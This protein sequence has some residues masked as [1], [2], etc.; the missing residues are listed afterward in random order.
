MKIH[1]KKFVLVL[2]FFT[3]M[4]KEEGACMEDPIS[5]SRARGHSLDSTH[6]EGKK[7]VKKRLFE[8]SKEGRKKTL[9]HAR[10]ERGDLEPLHLRLSGPSQ[11]QEFVSRSAG[12]FFLKK[13]FLT[14]EKVDTEGLEKVLSYF[15]LN[16]IVSFGTF[17]ICDPDEDGLDE[18]PA[19]IDERGAFL[20]ASFLREMSSSLTSFT[21]KDHPIGYKGLAA[22]LEALALKSALENLEITY[23][24]G[25]EILE[26]DEEYR[27]IE[28]SIEELLEGCR[29]LKTIGFRNTLALLNIDKLVANFAVLPLLQRLD[30]SDNYLTK[31]VAGIFLEAFK[32]KVGFTLDL[33]DNYIGQDNAEDLRQRYAPFLNVNLE[34]QA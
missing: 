26:E 23:V 32:G 33:S 29:N 11:I 24:C 19:Y 18:N 17:N 20:L 27:G 5:P 14:L 13:V 16:K 7:V 4:G 15:R 34:G 3:L 8:D 10:E 9:K 12:D 31:E 25:A 6:K 21:L 22:I 28:Q 1:I 2:C 30:L